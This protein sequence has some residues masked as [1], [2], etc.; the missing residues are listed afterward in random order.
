MDPKFKTQVKKIFKKIIYLNAGPKIF[1]G[2]IVFY[3]AVELGK[4]FLDFTSKE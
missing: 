2:G 1:L 3:C 4:D